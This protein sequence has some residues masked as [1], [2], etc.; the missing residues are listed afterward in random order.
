MKRY[1]EIIF[2]LIG[3]YGF[4]PASIAAQDGSSAYDFLRFP[5]SSRV[6]ALG[7]YSVSIVAPDPSLIFHNPALLGGEMDGMVNLN[8]MNYFADVN[9]GSAVFSKAFRERS[10][11]AVGAT[12]INYGSLREFTPEEVELGTFSIQNIGIHL[13]YSY[14]LTDKWRG[15]LAMKML[16]S[17]LADYTS[18]GL[19]VDAGLSYY[20]EESNFAFG[21]AL[22][23]IGA[24]LKAYDRERQNVP[25]DIQMGISKRMLHAPIRLSVTGMYLNRWKFDYTD[26]TKTE[27]IAQDNDRK[28]FPTLFKHVVLGIEFL[29]SDNFWLGVGFNPK[30]KMDMKLDSGNALGGFSVGGGL[31]VSR[32]NV[33]ASVARYHPSATSLM[34]SVSVGMNNE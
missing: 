30:T 10:A 7:G 34:V 18:Y 24:Q 5:T 2:L 21:L 6:N 31:R 22:K 8:Y 33:G 9:V 25:W 12:Y 20:D 29:P 1:I 15:G 13:M 3:F 11:W 19:A 26:D 14:D 4:F 32:F 17:A 27:T 28:F 23:H 16:Y